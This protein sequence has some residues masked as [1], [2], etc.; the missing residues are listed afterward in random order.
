MSRDAEASRPWA[1]DDGARP[2]PRI[3]DFAK[4]MRS[5]PTKAER[6]LWTALR[7]MQAGRSHFRRQVVVEGF[8]ADFACYRLKLIIEV[9]GGQHC[10]SEADVARTSKLEKAG[11][12]VMRFWNSDVLNNI[13]GVMGKIAE[14]LGVEES[15][16]FGTT[17]TPD[18]S[19]QGGG[20]K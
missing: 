5:E 19:P 7:R 11:W 16:I 3:V 10:E 13:D 17:P 8:V 14:A 15:A 4:I 12:R 2:R 20:E 6:R 9:D 18:P 1:L